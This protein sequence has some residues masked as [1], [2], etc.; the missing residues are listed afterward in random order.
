[1]RIFVSVLFLLFTVSGVTR[2]IGETNERVSSE[3]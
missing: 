3:R 2:K 1:M